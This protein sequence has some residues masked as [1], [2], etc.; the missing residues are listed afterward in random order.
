MEIRVKER[1]NLFDIALQYSG[2]MESAFA[3]SRQNGVSVTKSLETSESLDVPQVTDEKV[4]SNYASNAISPASCGKVI[5]NSLLTIIGGYEILTIN[6]N[7]P[8]TQI[9]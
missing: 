8:I 7:E 1:Q 2:S 6:T 5:M 9:G 4:T 3:I